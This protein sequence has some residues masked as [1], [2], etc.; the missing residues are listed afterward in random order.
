VR[1]RDWLLAAIGLSRACP[2]TLT[3]YAVGAIVVGPGGTEL[4]RGYSRESD[5]LDHAEEAALAKL[6][7]IDLRRA[8]MYTSLE[9]CTARR[10]RPRTCTG[11]ILAAGVGR[12]VFALR[13]PPL[14]AD[15]HGARTLRAAGVD[16]VELGDLG[17]VVREVN[18]HLFERSRW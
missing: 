14:F 17:H 9:P 6:P 1:D 18:A 2:R 13:E 11:M 5:P 16:V 12:V 7:G 8:T 4:A 15:C 3:A 10:S